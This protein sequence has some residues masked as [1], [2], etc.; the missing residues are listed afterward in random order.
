MDGPQRYVSEG[1]GFL[2]EG[3]DRGH[4]DYPYAGKAPWNEIWVAF[5]WH[6]EVGSA[7]LDAPVGYGTLGEWADFCIEN[8]DLEPE[9]AREVLRTILADG[10]YVEGGGAAPIGHLYRIEGPEEI[11]GSAPAP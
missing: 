2:D 6:K 11:L 9:Q 7:E 10:Q 1:K 4:A 5:A 8:S 3:D